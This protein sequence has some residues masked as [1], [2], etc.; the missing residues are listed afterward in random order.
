MYTIAENDLNK[1]FLISFDS[2]STLLYAIHET[3]SWQLT[4]KIP[5]YSMIGTCVI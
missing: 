4:I 3:A 1:L 2:F 5:Y